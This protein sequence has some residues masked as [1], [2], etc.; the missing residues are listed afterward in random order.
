M[1]LFRGHKLCS[2][3]LAAATMMGIQMTLSSQVHVVYLLATEMIK[4]KSLGCNLCSFVS[5]VVK[6]NLANLSLIVIYKPVC[7]VFN[8][9]L[10]TETS[11]FFTLQQRTRET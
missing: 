4:M 7:S 11:L 2:V 1:F 10:I 6:R 5:A 8:I 3:D 9:E